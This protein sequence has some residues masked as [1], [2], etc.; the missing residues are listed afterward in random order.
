[1]THLAVGEYLDTAYNRVF[2]DQVSSDPS[3][4]HDRG[5]DVY[6]FGQSIW[7][8]HPIPFSPDPEERSRCEEAPCHGSGADGRSSRLLRS[9]PRRGHIGSRSRSL[10]ARRAVPD[11]DTGHLG[12]CRQACPQTNDSQSH[13]GTE[14]APARDEQ[15]PADWQAAAFH[16][17]HRQALQPST[18]VLDG[19][20]RVYGCLAGRTAPNYLPPG[21]A[22]PAVTATLSVERRDSNPTIGN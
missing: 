12:G 3:A 5:I 18:P 9:R 7:D 14:T 15:P 11:A 19:V 16:L 6:P 1:V 10:G 22:R 17:H 13:P 20:L 8:V 21:P 4:S 2:W